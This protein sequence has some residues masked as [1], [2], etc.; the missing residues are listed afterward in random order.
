MLTLVFILAEN[1]NFTK[2]LNNP[3]T[4]YVLK[5]A[6]VYAIVMPLITLLVETLLGENLYQLVQD[7]L[8][9]FQNF[10]ISFIISYTIGVPLALLVWHENKKRNSGSN[11]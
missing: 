11:F 5:W 2:M 3:K 9:N 1:Q 8:L 10:G 7:K 4:R 6:L